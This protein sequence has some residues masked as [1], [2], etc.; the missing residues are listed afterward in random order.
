MF[1][2]T[3]HKEFCSP[4]VKR[5]WKKKKKRTDNAIRLTIRLT[6]G[7][8]VD[9]CCGWTKN[10]VSQLDVARLISENVQPIENQ[11]Q[12]QSLNQEFQVLASKSGYEF[13]FFH[14]DTWLAW[15]Q[16]ECRMMFV[17]DTEFPRITIRNSLQI[18]KTTTTKW[19]SVQVSCFP[20]SWLVLLNPYSKRYANHFRRPCHQLAHQVFPKPNTLIRRRSLAGLDKNETKV[21]GGNAT[22]VIEAKGEP[23]GK[24]SKVDNEGTEPVVEKVE[25]GDVKVTEPSAAGKAEKK[26]GGEEEEETGPAEKA[27][28]EDS[29]AEEVEKKDK[30]VPGT[31]DIWPDKTQ[32]LTKV[33]IRRQKWSPTIDNGS[34]LCL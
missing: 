23:E 19:S 28:K 33:A 18:Q 12:W 8:A 9:L 4:G 16:H 13:L 21:E 10:D 6:N 29:D 5:P 3:D 22:A 30:E 34:N 27:D 17:C 15:G 20:S 7:C 2:R 24:V 26:E 14:V 11:P 25:G 31:Y 1:F 32:S